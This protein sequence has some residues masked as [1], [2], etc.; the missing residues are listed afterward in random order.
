MLDHGGRA[1][2]PTSRA[3]APLR[4]GAS[5]LQGKGSSGNVWTVRA[6]PST[7]S[8][9]T[10]SSAYSENKTKSALHEWGNIPIRQADQPGCFNICSKGPQI[11]LPVVRRH[12]WRSK[13]GIRGAH[14]LRPAAAK[15]QCHI[16]APSRN[17]SSMSGQSLS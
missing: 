15:S 16:P 8:T 1:A 9:A 14:W 4:C 6:R 7:P 13:V 11:A 12:F 3:Q 2:A 10:G 5:D 17:R